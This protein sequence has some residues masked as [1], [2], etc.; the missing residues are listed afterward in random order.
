MPRSKKL[1]PRIS[2][3]ADS[4]RTELYS[5]FQTP[6]G[7]TWLCSASLV[8]IAVSPKLARMELFWR[9]VPRNQ[10]QLS[11]PFGVVRRSA[12]TVATSSERMCVSSSSV[13]WFCSSRCLR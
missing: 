3:T 9:F 10:Y 13:S 2:N 11:L 8:T 6:L 7:H 12:F 4:P 5:T 1:P